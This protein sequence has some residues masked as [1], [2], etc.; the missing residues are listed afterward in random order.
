M[1]GVKLYKIANISPN[2]L[3]MAPCGVVKKGQNMRSKQ[4]NK[5]LF[6]R[7]SCMFQK[8]VLILQHLKSTFIHTIFS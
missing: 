5:G 3:P 8:I 2:S 6:T 1:S 7:K 4:V